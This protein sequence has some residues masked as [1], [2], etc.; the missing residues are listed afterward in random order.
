MLLSAL[1]ERLRLSF[2]GD[3]DLE[4]TGVASLE[5]A[6]PGDLSFV[7]SERWREA[8]DKSAAGAVLAAP[9]L[10]C[11]TRPVLRSTRPR[12]D[13]ARAVGLLRPHL[14][15]APGIHPTAAVDADANV[16]PHAA[17]GARAV[18][19]PG[20]VV[21]SGTAVH[22]NAT[23]YPDVQLG[24]DCEIHAGCVLREGTRVGDRVILQPGVILGGD[25]FGYEPGEDGEWEKIPQ[26]GIVVVE[27]DVEIGAGTTIDR[28]S[29]GETR[30]G[31]GVKI[32][33]LVQIGHNCVIGQD[34]L[35]VAQSG[36]GG[37]TRVG[38]RAI[39]MGRT[40][41]AGHLSIGDG[42][43]V[44]GRG[45]VVRDLAAGRRAFGT[46]AVE[47]RTWH[48]AMAALW[49]LPEAMRRLRRLEKRVEALDSEDG[50][51]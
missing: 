32:D 36:L 35:V 45:S 5:D 14:R 7:T 27:D 26:V 9:D 33:N 4:L 18:I 1:A 47:E 11:G 39:L 20:C 25:G 17:V 50:D 6:G 41:S 13:F 3:V 19:G 46:P 16:S 31:R 24:S 38:R 8:L 15:P 22:A 29:L 43:F 37:S 42:A 40:A 2:E 49:R 34:A 12:R 10:D 28:A 30:I 44:A 23:L 21:G 48:R 51:A